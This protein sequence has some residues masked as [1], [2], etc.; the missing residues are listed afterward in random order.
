MVQTLGV[1]QSWRRLN[2]GW[3]IR[4]YDDE[5]CLEFVSREFPEYLEAYRVLPKHV[6]RSDFFRYMVRLHD[7][8]VSWNL[9]LGL[10]KCSFIMV[11]ANNFARAYCTRRR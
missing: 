5:A 2:P 8:P 7:A 10:L 4:F 1:L 3:E 6:E 9:M 11:V